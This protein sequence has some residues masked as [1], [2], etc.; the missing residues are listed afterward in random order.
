[1]MD[2]ASQ[3][4]ATMTGSQGCSELPCS[5]TTRSVITTFCKAGCAIS[6]PDRPVMVT[7]DGPRSGHFAMSFSSLGH[8]EGEMLC[9]CVSVVFQGVCEGM[10]YEEIAA[11]YP[12]EFAE[13]D[14][15]KYHYR[16]PTGEVRR[17]RTASSIL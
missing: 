4:D 11:Q 1:M 8:A 12:A 17:A 7:G 3:V 6:L 13:R 9:T 5:V 14:A 2:A 10:T 16:Y 15:D